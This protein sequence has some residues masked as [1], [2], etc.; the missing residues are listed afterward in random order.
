MPIP[1]RHMP[2]EDDWAPGRRGDAHTYSQLTR[3]IPREVKSCFQLDR[4]AQRTCQA[5]IT[6]SV[7]VADIQKSIRGIWE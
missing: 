3:F 1:R 4:R 2:A 5:K 7:R 6:A